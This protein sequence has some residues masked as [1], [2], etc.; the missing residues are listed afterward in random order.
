MQLQAARRASTY[1]QSKQLAPVHREARCYTA[2]SDVAALVLL[3]SDRN[4]APP[5]SATHLAGLMCRHP[6]GD[7]CRSHIY[8]GPSW[9]SS[10]AVTLWVSVCVSCYDLSH[11]GCKVF[12]A[13]RAFQQREKSKGSVQ[14]NVI[15]SSHHA[16][17][18][19]F[20][21]EDC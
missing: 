8:R 16:D 19:H 1:L 9:L 5:S 12:S 10:A 20:P 3:V 18:L 6:L 7:R 11:T 15:K 4:W 13:I 21:H 14:P 2:V 17:S